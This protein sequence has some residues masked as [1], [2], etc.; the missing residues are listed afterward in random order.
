MSGTDIPRGQGGG[1]ARL[2]QVGGQPMS[3][4]LFPVMGEAQFHAL[5]RQLASGGSG[6]S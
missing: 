2:T 1:P 5:A 6:K 4:P 3:P